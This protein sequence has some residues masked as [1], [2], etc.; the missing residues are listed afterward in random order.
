MFVVVFIV[1]LLLMAYMQPF[2]Q[3]KDFAGPPGTGVHEARIFGFARI[4][5]IGTV[6][7]SVV[8]SFLIGTNLFWSF[9]T[10]IFLSIV[11]HAAFGVQT[12]L[13]TLLNLRV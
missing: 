13:M 4:D 1:G 12:E 7:G 11:V 10:L 5:M 2:K 6:I 9:I 8:L 3:Y